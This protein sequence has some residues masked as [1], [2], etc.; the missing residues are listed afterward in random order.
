M[1]TGGWP[2]PQQATQHHC[3]TNLKE[4]LPVLPLYLN[5]EKVDSAQ[6][7][8]SERAVREQLPGHRGVL[9]GHLSFYKRLFYSLVF[10]MLVST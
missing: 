3:S 9:A 8:P 5:S 4:G 7:A 10:L 6:A 2:P 1:R